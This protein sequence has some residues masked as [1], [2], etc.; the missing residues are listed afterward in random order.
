MWRPERAAGQAEEGG[1]TQ[2][3]RLFFAFKKTMSLSA[4]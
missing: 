4:K 1:I 2:V 3:S